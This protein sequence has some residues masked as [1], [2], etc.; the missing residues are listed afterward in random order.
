MTGSSCAG[1]NALS[2]A[3]S[4]RQKGGPKVGQT[5]RGKGTKWMVRVDGAGTPLGADLDAASPAEVTLIEKTL[6]T[7]AVR[8][9]GTPGRPRKRPDRLMADRG[10]DSN[11]VRA[12]LARLAAE[13]GRRGELFGG[14]PGLGGRPADLRSPPRLM[15]APIGAF[16]VKREEL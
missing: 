10:D 2:M 15:L 5:K 16:T 14:D 8:R 3:A 13:R 4:S 1:M 6:D 9:P 12:R 7:I 11:P